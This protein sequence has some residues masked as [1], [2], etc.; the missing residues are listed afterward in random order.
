MGILA[1]TS[2]QNHLEV[3]SFSDLFTGGGVAAEWAAGTTA[4]VRAD[5]S[6]WSCNLVGSD[7]HH[8]WGFV[9][10]PL[11]TESSLSW[12]T[13]AMPLVS[14]N[15]P[16]GTMRSWYAILPTR[17]FS[18]DQSISRTSLEVDYAGSG[19]FVPLV[20]GVDYGLLPR[21]P[22]VTGAPGIGIG[23][24]LQ[25]RPYGGGGPRA[26]VSDQAVGFAVSSSVSAAT[27]SSSVF[28][29]AWK[30]RTLLAEAF[31]AK[32][33]IIETVAPFTSE[34]SFSTPYA[35]AHANSVVSF[36]NMPKQYPLGSFAVF[37]HP[38][39]GYRVEI[40]RRPHRT[41]GGSYRDTRNLQVG[42]RR[43]ST[44]LSL[45]DRTQDG[46]FFGTVLDVF[47]SYYSHEQEYRWCYWS[48]ELQARS[49][50]SD[51]PIFRSGFRWM[52]TN[53]TQVIFRSGNIFWIGL[54]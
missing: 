54:R 53:T 15:A 13:S 34:P 4:H 47:A 14:G 10:S 45:L 35:V 40:W 46:V 28:R 5:G 39:E 31:G 52:N 6:Q 29:F 32:A 42:L 8:E 9:S 20:Y 23:Y 51:L 26:S 44:G 48:D 33:A 2:S 49:R 18:S 1:K 22:M 36:P 24:G 7:L 3:E 38:I 19:T 12:K 27:T 21:T 37:F 16:S 43:L 41:E 50:M 30:E 25:S 17:N 11:Y